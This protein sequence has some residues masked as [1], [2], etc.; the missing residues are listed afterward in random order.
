[1]SS[2]KRKSAVELAA[3]DA[4]KPKQNASITSFFAQPKPAASAPATAV[5]P[6]SST[7]SDG[8]ALGV[9]EADGVLGTATSSVTTIP[10][11]GTAATPAEVFTSTT[12]TTAAAPARKPFDKEAWI[13][14]LTA[15]QKEL[16]QLEI[17][18]LHDSWLAHLADEITS[19]EFLNLKKF[20]KSEIES[21]QKIF[22]PLE[23]VYS[24]YELYHLLLHTTL[25][26]ITGD[27]HA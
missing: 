21:G 9:V 16:L 3:A 12:T 13:A 11:S 22:P 8:T 17:D 1:M 5:I 19:K 20:L 4:K 7:T 26:P 24:W 23:D 18:T 6:K 15:E 10:G 2:L 14:K 27:A 25:I